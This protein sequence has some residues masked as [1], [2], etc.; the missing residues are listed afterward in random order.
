MYA[1]FFVSCDAIALAMQSAGGA[2]TSTADDADMRTTGTNVM[3]AGLAFQVA[4]LTLFIYLGSE[5]AFRL[6]RRT[7]EAQRNGSSD[8]ENRKDDGYAAI[9]EKRRWKVWIFSR[10]PKPYVP[11]LG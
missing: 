9:R 8:S 7:R 10:S 3:I 1:I 4:A 11:V 2:I 5:F 6:R